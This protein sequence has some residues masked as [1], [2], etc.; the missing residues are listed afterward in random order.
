L[1]RRLPSDFYYWLIK[2]PA[3]GSVASFLYS[4]P[5]VNDFK[6]FLGEPIK[7]ITNYPPATFPPGFM[8]IYERFNGKQKIVIN[9]T[10]Q[11][12]SKEDLS[13]LENNLLKEL[14]G[15]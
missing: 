10:L 4:D 13:I 12:V 15:D 14:L 8:T 11:V 5:G 9:H 2:G 7:N 3:E 1:L 6:T